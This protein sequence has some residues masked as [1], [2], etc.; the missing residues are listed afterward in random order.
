MTD[1]KVLDK[2]I[3]KDLRKISPKM[4]TLIIEDWLSGSDNLHYVRLDQK[5]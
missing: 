5:Q 3:T 1:S 4:K 2:I